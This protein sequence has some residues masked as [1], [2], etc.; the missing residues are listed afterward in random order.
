MSVYPNAAHTLHKDKLY[1]SNADIEAQKQI[2][3]KQEY[4]E[5]NEQVHSVVASVKMSHQIPE[6]W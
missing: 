5:K 4:T 1:K 2:V 3:R 6:D